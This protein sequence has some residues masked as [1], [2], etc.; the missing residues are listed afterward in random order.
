VLYELESYE[1]VSSQRVRHEW[2]AQDEV[3]SSR[4]QNVEQE[5][6]L[7]WLGEV[8]RIAIPIQMLMMVLLGFSSLYEMDGLPSE[9]VICMFQ[10]TMRDSFEPMMFWKHGPPPT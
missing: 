8:A 3:D 4:R 1:I 2:L 5:E 10:N 6:Q 7:P 9:E